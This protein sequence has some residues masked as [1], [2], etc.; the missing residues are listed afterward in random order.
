M[1]TMH[2]TRTLPPF[3]SLVNDRLYALGIFLCLQA[4]DLATTL[5]ALNSGVL[6]EGNPFGAM[7]YDSYGGWGLSALKTAAVLLTVFGVRFLFHNRWFR[8]WLFGVNICMAGIIAHNLWLL[9]VNA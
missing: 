5:F 3:S 8:N 6:S 9:T 1:Q 7:A 4:L 2:E